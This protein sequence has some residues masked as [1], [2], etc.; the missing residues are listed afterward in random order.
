MY[1]QGSMKRKDWTFSLSSSAIIP[2]QL[3]SLFFPLYP[4]LLWLYAFHNLHTFFDDKLFVPV[5]SSQLASV[6]VPSQTAFTRYAVVLLLQL[7]FLSPPPPLPQYNLHSFPD[8]V[9][10]SPLALLPSHSYH[11]YSHSSQPPM[12]NPRV[13]IF[14]PLA[15]SS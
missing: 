10:I 9:V 2:I 13:P 14:S 6:C 3:F 8:K 15:V 11:F 5:S 4:F 7:P 12:L 1:Q